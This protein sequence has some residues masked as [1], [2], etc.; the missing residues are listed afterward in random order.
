MRKKKCLTEEMQGKWST[1]R[2]ETTEILDCRSFNPQEEEKGRS[3]KPRESMLRLKK[4][5]CI[6]SEDR[7]KRKRNR[8]N[9]QQ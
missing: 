7:T 1:F 9:Q 2:K 6:I 8:T 4:V 5:C 3:A